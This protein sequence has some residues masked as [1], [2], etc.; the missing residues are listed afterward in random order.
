MSNQEEEIEVLV[1]VDRS[2]ENTGEEEQILGFKPKEEYSINPPW[3]QKGNKKEKTTKKIQIRKQASEKEF[4]LRKKKDTRFEEGKVSPHGH[5]CPRER[6][7]DTTRSDICRIKIGHQ[8]PG[9][10]GIDEPKEECIKKLEEEIAKHL[11]PLEGSER[12]AEA[13]KQMEKWLTMSD[14]KE[15]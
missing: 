1:C 12:K 8:C 5:K 10:N 11:G 7:K 6:L 4:T 15:T 2:A 3:E 9:C 14:L 13:E